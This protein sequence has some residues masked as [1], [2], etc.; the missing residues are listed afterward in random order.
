MSV[1]GKWSQLVIDEDGGCSACFH[2]GQGTAMAVR[3]GDGSDAWCCMEDGDGEGSMLVLGMIESMAPLTLASVSFVGS[4][5]CTT[6]RVTVA[7]SSPSAN[8]GAAEVASTTN[9]ISDPNRNML[10]VLS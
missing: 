6:R 2:C 8:N 10:P 9:A 1:V 4:I 5:I 7:M 3:F